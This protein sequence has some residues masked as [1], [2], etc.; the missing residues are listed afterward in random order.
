MIDLSFYGD[1]FTGSTDVMEAL[2]SNGI[3]TVLFTRIPTE[4][5]RAAFPDARAVGLAG[6]SRSRPPEWMDEH[7]PRIFDWLKSQGA[8]HCHY[9]TCSTFD[10][11][12]HLGSIG[13][14]AEIGLAAFGQT[15]A[16][17][18]VGAPQ[19][20]RYTLFGTL[21]AAYQAEVYRIDRHPVMA[22]HPATPM[23]EADLRQHLA[24]QTDLP[25]G[26]IDPDSLRATTPLDAL[27]AARDRGARLTLIDVFDT[28][29]QHRAGTLVEAAR[30]ETGPF[31][32]GSSGVEYALLRHW[33]ATGRTEPTPQTA[34]LDRQEAIAVVSGSCSPTT[35]RQIRS[36]LAA[37]FAGIA[38]DYTALASGVGAEQA[39]DNA[40]NQA[41]SAL[42]NRQSPLI[43]TALG[44]AS[45]PS[46]QGNDRVGRALGRL[47]RG[48]IDRFPLQRVVI[49]GG[50]TSSHALAELDCHAL[51]LRRPLPDTPGSP[52][53]T[54]HGSGRTFEIALK[55]GQ[56]GRDGYFLHLRDGD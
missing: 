50:D 32:L 4:A 17:V 24:A 26:L 12:P 30:D 2:S 10:S 22:R 56:V 6:E 45:T 39:L 43:Y 38:V 33:Q 21:F 25:C 15:H 8:R 19:L 53:C 31:I 49:A 1:D 29:S 23:A 48:L 47:L 54:A 35:E 40:R 42:S 36:A 52:V 51:T 16:H 37:G 28:N 11:A 3:P 20:R 55:G 18:I 46:T 7:L 27:R 44:P 14:A 34:P 5:Q 13:R 9:K 41:Q